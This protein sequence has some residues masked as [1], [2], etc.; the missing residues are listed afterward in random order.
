MY[1]GNTNRLTSSA[2]TS[3]TRVLD[4]FG[5]SLIWLRSRRWTS[6]ASCGN[7]TERQRRREP[8]FQ[9]GIVRI[10]EGYGCL[11]YLRLIV[12]KFTKLGLPLWCSH[13]QESPVLKV[14]G[15]RGSCREMDRMF[16]LF[17]RNRMVRLEDICGVT[18]FDYV[19]EEICG[20][21]VFDYVLQCLIH[22]FLL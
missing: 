21:T 8:P 15:S 19:F 3:A 16:N 2:S 4:S 18:V 5:R 10:H 13:C 14:E 12:R 22:D 1:R 9:G 20:A 17:V 6:P 11:A 7:A